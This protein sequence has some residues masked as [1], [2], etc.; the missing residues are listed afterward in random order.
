MSEDMA[1]TADDTVI[2]TK[3]V[4]K[5]EPWIQPKATEKYRWNGKNFCHFM[6][7][8]EQRKNGVYLSQ[9]IDTSQEQARENAKFDIRTINGAKSFKIEQVTVNRLERF[10][11]VDLNTKKNRTRGETIRITVVNVTIK[12]RRQRLE[13]R[14]FYPILL[15]KDNDL[16]EWALR[17]DTGEIIYKKEEELEKICIVEVREYQPKDPETRVYYIIFFSDGTCRK[18]EVSD[19]YTLEFRSNAV[20]LRNGRWGQTYGVANWQHFSH[21]YP[22]K[23]NDYMKISMNGSYN[24]YRTVGKSQ[25]RRVY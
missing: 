10:G 12:R 7:R 15:Y 22:V 4:W 14:T 23:C 9:Y 13:V 1:T 5:K 24:T 3:K 8:I 19:N 16:I 18:E 20:T 11:D 25:P 17:D 2:A 6:A 21:F